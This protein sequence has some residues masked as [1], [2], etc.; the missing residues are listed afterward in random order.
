MP[1]VDL[2]L[3]PKSKIYVLHEVKANV[4]YDREKNMSQTLNNLV[5]IVDTPF[6]IFF[7]V[8]L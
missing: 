4:A 8:L 3:F 5:S 6:S 7:D 1:H 2:W